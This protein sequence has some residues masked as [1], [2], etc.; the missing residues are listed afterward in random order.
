MSS[1]E[2]MYHGN[3]S[4]LINKVS[5]QRDKIAA[6]KEMKEMDIKAKNTIVDKQIDSRQQQ[7]VTMTREQMLD[8]ILKQAN[9]IE[10]ETVDD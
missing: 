6:Q 10:A 3:N 5:L 7:Q 1:T 2:I 8:H 9:V 4:D